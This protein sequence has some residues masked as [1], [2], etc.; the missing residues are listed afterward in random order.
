MLLLTKELM[1]DVIV[2]HILGCHVLHF[3]E[4]YYIQGMRK[5]IKYLI[6]RTWTYYC[7]PLLQF[8]N[9]PM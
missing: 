7:K 9:V 3:I 4:R 2:R 6:F 5:I 8:C 1:F